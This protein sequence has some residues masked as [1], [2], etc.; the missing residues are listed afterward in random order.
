M[1]TGSFLMKIAVLCLII[2]AGYTGYKY[3]QKTKFDSDL[4]KIVL[5]LNET[6]K[7]AMTLDID[8]VIGS[9][10][11]KQTVESLETNTLKWSK[12]LKDISL[13]LPLDKRGNAVVEIT[14]YS[15]SSGSD[16]SLNVKTRQD[17]DNP[18]T[19][20]QKL[21]RSFDESNLFSDTFIPSIS[22]GLDE[23]GNK[24]LSFMLSTK[25]VGSEVDTS[26]SLL[27]T[28]EDAPVLIEESPVIPTETTEIPAESTG[29]TIPR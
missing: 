6:K 23:K 12:V 19:D 17:S 8:K 14:S 10:S 3:Y 25:Y 24:I 16:L 28:S 29:T 27:E 18:Y 26:T 9:M 7:Q 1:K 22:M 15:G 5:T 13:T 4:K 20:V 2:L 11:A 21:I